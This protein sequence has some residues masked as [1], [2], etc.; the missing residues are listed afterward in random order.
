MSLS[1]ATGEWGL[2]EEQRGITRELLL[3][4]DSEDVQEAFF[5]LKSAA[6]CLSNYNIYY[7]YC[8]YYK[9]LIS[10]L[11]FFLASDVSSFTSQYDH[12]HLA[13]DICFTF[14]K[15]DFLGIW[16]IPWCPGQPHVN[17]HAHFALCPGRV[18]GQAR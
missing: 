11:S 5:R 10:A 16:T 2:D 15:F 3:S 12:E 6:L 1:A 14:F 7:N 9:C 17:S 8:I 4:S 18:E 13:A